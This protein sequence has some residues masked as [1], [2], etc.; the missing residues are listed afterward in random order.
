[1]LEIVRG[2]TWTQQHTV[3][4][5]EDGPLTDLSIFSEIKSQIRERTAKRN[6]KTGY[7]ENAVVATVAV[8]FEE[9]V[10][11]QTLTRAATYALNVGD[12]IVDIV[13]IL[14]EG[15]DESLLTPEPV[16]VT[17]RPTSVT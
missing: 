5:N 7:F 14:S 9:S 4:D 3:L 16:R 10:I 15:G 13:G 1:M 8:T 2:R 11:T 12:Y 17:N 6:P